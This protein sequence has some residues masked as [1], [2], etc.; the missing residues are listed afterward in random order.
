MPGSYLHGSTPSKVLSSCG[1]RP[2]KV[3]SQ[4]NFGRLPGSDSFRARTIDRGS[5][6]FSL[7]VSMEQAEF[8]VVLL[9]ST[10]GN[11]N[12]KTHDPFYRHGDDG[13]GRACP[14]RNSD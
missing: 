10:R 6:D 12:E 11:I 3:C 8:L 7:N 14:E 5:I 2:V 1:R 13:V 9:F 4:E